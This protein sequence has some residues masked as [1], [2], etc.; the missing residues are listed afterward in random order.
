MI[1]QI[2]KVK[3]ELTKYGKKRD[4]NE[5]T[6][7]AIK[8]LFTNFLLDIQIILFEDLKF[9][10]KNVNEVISNL[11]NDYENAF[12]KEEFKLHFKYEP[13]IYKIKNTNG[14]K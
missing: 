9:S 4:I 10:K 2:S 13:K 14:K 11:K 1:K 6:I 3:L 12:Y 8:N 5:K 7:S